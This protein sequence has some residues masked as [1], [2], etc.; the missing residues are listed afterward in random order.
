MS[1]WTRMKAGLL[2]PLPTTHVEGVPESDPPTKFCTG[3]APEVGVPAPGAAPG[4]GPGAELSVK[5]SS[6]A[7]VAAR[8][9]V[10][11]SARVVS[12]SLYSSCSRSCRTRIALETQRFALR[13]FLASGLVRL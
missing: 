1:R 11:V 5:V 6:A 10:R 13:I 8:G 4:K 7:R 9:A 12:C 3:V 2:M